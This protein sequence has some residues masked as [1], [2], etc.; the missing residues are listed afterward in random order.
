[1]ARS[2]QPV[3]EV[4]STPQKQ[5]KSV[6]PRKVTKATQDFVTFHD[7]NTPK[8]VYVKSSKNRDRQTRTK[9][10]SESKK[11]TFSLNKNMTAGKGVG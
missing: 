6:A 7:T 11:V 10:L 1:M 3:G 9:I 4:S 2:G 8:P 5:E